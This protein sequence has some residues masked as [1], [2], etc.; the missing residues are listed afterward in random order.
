MPIKDNFIDLPSYGTLKLLA[1]S[2]IDLTDPEVLT[3]ERIRKFVAKS[4]QFSILF[5]M[6]RVTD[7]VIAALE[8]L[9]RERDVFQ[10]MQKMQN[11]E[12][13]NFIEGFSS[14][15]RAVL[16]T[17]LRDFFEDPNPKK[18]ASQ[19]REM[20]HIEL[21]RIKAFEAELA[22]FENLIV[23]GIGGSSL[24]PEAVYLGLK[25]FI[26]PGKGVRFIS[27]VDPDDAYQVL[28]G[29]DPSKTLTLVNT[30]TGTTE[31]T[32]TNEALVRAWYQEHGIE[33]KN[34]F[35]VVTGEGSPLDDKSRYRKCFYIWD[36]VGGRFS[37]SSA[38]GGLIITFAFG[39]KVYWD[40][41]KGAHEMDRAALNEDIT[42]NL[43]LL[44][45]LLSIWNTNFL[46]Y[47]SLAIIPYSQALSRLSAHVQQ[48]EMESNGKGIDKQGKPLT[49]K[50]ASVL[51]G[52]PGTNGQH[53]FF[54]MIHQGTSVVP[55]E[56]IGF[57]T[58]QIKKDLLQNNVT[59]Q[60]KLLAN[61]FAQSL[62]LAKGQKSDNPNKTFSGNRPSHILLAEKL[63]PEALGALIA[64]YEHK[65][66]FEGFIWN[67]N[68][69]DQE[70][71]QLGK[72]LA[73]RFVDL[74]RAKRGAKIKIEASSQETA[75]LNTLDSCF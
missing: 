64:Y 25:G 69:F 12:V 68:S 65:A 5:A 56:F 57:K 15:N 17:A 42:E 67:I 32:L 74:F 1:E 51:W 49:Y 70:G 59:S 43:P 10:E 26:N 58:S 60:E 6:E 8:N 28:R 7:E 33:S 16:H 13:L 3:A 48:V 14:E 55:I 21:M 41:L 38:I 50:T 2:P 34:H 24:G 62:A 20:A 37:A 75:L 54:Q 39:F 45:A 47:N 4:A 35:I 23:I 18:T 63:T 44:G 9:A 31:E 11:G 36:W 73:S 52:E 19:A 27:N 53:S 66:A 46:G 71:V 61:L 40:F 22:P 29:L 72:A 30:K